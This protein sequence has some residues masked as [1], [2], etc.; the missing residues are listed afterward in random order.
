VT[1]QFHPNLR[2]SSYHETCQ[3]RNPLSVSF[4]YTTQNRSIPVFRHRYSGECTDNVA[5]RRLLTEAAAD[6]GND[7]GSTLLLAA[8]SATTS[9]ASGGGALGGC[10]PP[11]A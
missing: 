1:R 9:D 7:G 10:V 8:I 2:F 3:Q 6:G 11:F 5:G 4:R